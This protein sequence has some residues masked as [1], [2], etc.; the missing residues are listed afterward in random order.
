MP[1]VENKTSLHRQ[2][3]PSLESGKHM[4]LTGMK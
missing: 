1:E 2:K 4:D 3:I